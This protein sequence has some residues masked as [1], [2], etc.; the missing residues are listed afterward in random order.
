MSSFTALTT[1]G[2]PN[3]PEAGRA[4]EPRYL[5][6]PGA[7]AGS[8]CFARCTCD[9]EGPVPSY[10]AEIVMIWV[11]T[12]RCF[13]SC[14]IKKCNIPCVYWVSCAYPK[15]RKLVGWPGLEP[16]TNGLKG[17]CSTD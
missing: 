12:S 13:G 7:S 1:S 5:A 4:C 6:A 17:R 16:G 10:L 11:L 2:T 3:Q 9:L 14:E 15:G 8:E